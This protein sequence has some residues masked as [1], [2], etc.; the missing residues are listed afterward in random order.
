MGVFLRVAAMIGRCRASR[1]CELFIIIVIFTYFIVSPR[2]LDIP[3]CPSIYLRGVPCPTC[4][5]TRAMWHILHGR[6]ASAW[7]LNPIGFLVVLVL[8]RRVI[9]LSVHSQSANRWL[10]NERVDF[11]LFSMFLLLGFAR[12]FQTLLNSYFP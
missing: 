12:L 1:G 5:T 2:L 7:A 3:S 6:F 11:V 9:V 8:A 10:Q 4:G